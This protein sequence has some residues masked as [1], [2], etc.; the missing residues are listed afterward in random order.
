MP[1]L[2]DGRGRARCQASAGRTCWCE[3]HGDDRCLPCTGN[4]CGMGIKA[5]TVGRTR[6]VRGR[7]RRYL[8]C[9]ASSVQAAR[10]VFLCA[11][12]FKQPTPSPC[13]LACTGEV[14]VCPLRVGTAVQNSTFVCATCIQSKQVCQKEGQDALI[15]QKGA[16]AQGGS[17]NLVCTGLLWCPSFSFACL[18]FGQV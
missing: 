13:K 2:V 9:A 14:S 11:S 18:P 6:S 7:D 12:V 1:G 17:G 8:F 10:Q 16:V 5:S 4:S 15:L 3:A